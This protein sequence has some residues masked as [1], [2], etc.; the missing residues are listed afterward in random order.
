VVDVFIFYQYVVCSVL[1]SKADFEEAL[2]ALTPSLSVDELNHYL[3]LK[4]SFQG[5]RTK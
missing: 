5:S 2:A 1:V 4:A 3:R